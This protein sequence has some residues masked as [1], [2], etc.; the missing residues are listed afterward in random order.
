MLNITKYFVSIVM[1]SLE[2]RSGAPQLFFR[3]VLTIGT[4]VPK[5][6][7][8]KDLLFK[9][10]REERRHRR[11]MVIC[12][13]CVLMNA[14]NLVKLKCVRACVRA[15]PAFVCM[16]GRQPCKGWRQLGRQE[17]GGDD[18]RGGGGGGEGRE[19]RDRR[20]G[21]RYTL[22]CSAAWLISI[23]LFPASA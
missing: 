19:S 12:L 22:W 21:V 9:M 8:L 6:S 17:E 7:K 16:Q 1:D 18:G 13:F 15:R 5:E 3:L 14:R 4:L 23:L 2:Y 20:D 10:T 11:L